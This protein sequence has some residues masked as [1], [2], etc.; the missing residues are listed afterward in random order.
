MNMLKP[1]CNRSNSS[2]RQKAVASGIKV[3]TCGP[4]AM[5]ALIVSKVQAGHTEVGWPS[6]TYVL[7]SGDTV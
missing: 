7:S 1:C 4:V 3:G 5:A 2:C 6:S